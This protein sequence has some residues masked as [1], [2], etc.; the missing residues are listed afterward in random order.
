MTAVSIPINSTS[1]TQITS[2][3][4]SAICW[5]IKNP[6]YDRIL[7]DHSSTGI[8][9]LSA[10][11]AYS[12]SRNKEVIRALNVDGSSDIFYA[13]CNREGQ[14]AVVVID[15]NNVAVGNTIS[16]QNS[17]STP[18]SAAGY[19]VG[20]WVDITSYGIIYVNVYSDVSSAFDGLE[21]QQSSDGINADHSDEFTVPASKGKNYSINPHS[22]Y[23]RVIYYNGTSDQTEF[24]LQ[25]KL[26]CSGLDSSHR[27]KDDL[28]TDDDA[29][30][31]KS[32]LMTKANDQDEYKNIELNNPMPVN[33]GQLYPHDIN[34][35]HS[36]QYNFSGTA[37]DLL[38]DRWSPIVD[39]TSTNPKLL[40]MEFERPM[41]TSIIGMVTE[42]GDFS[43]VVVKF[44][45][46]GG[47]FYTLYDGSSDSTKRTILVTPS[48]PITLNKILLEFHTTD[49]VT[50]TG[51]NLAKSNQV[52]S[53]LQG[54]DPAGQLRTI[55]ATY[56]DNLNVSI[57]EYGDT[58]AI[59]P[60]AS[61]R[62]STPFTIFDSK[63]LYDNQPL[64][65]DESLGGSTT[66]SHSTT[67]ARTR[68]T[69]T[70]SASDF[71]IRQTK[72]RFNYQPGKGQKIL[73]TSLTTQQTGVL[74][75]FGLFD[76][77]STNYMTPNNGIFFSVSGTELRWNIAKNGSTTES[78]EQA[79]WNYDKLD[80]SG[81]SRITFNAAGTHIAII[82]FEWLG[83]GRVRVG[84]VID[85]IIRYVHYF[86]HSNT[87][88]F[89]SIY[90]S[91]PNL[92]IRYDIQSDGTGS[93][94]ID[95]ICST[96]ISE[97]GL[98]ETGISRSIDTAFTQLDANAANTTYI[99]LGLRLKSTHLD[100]TVLPE[101][102]SMISQTNDDFRWSL[103]LNPTYNG[104][105]TWSDI[106]NSGCQWARGD[107]T[108]VMTIPG[109]KF[110]SG[111]SKSASSIDRRIKTS[112]RIGSTINL[113]RDELILAAMPLA[114]NAD[115]QGSLTFRELL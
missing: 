64:F 79:D 14:T 24:R 66:S 65:Y 15:D 59:D 111:Y 73:L 87:S 107:T 82:D 115:L 99:M 71:G 13:R 42:T 12:L 22:K 105:L 60:F 5:V 30:L 10:S 70:A 83:V 27:V 61:L 89:T 4:Q 6:D 90:M 28:T 43:N 106:S 88:S 32:I 21:I 29:R 63:Q 48:I 109:T 33:G 110:D 68:L 25:T 45:I 44:A 85:G 114:S 113:T 1:W 51:F 91:T 36:D 9:T 75:R 18:L 58:P 96:V 94:F 67:E 38:D 78:V 74:K 2:A 112:L 76:G 54:I 53:Q 46:G 95:H 35:E 69:V 84:F 40:L 97:G 86:S 101:F 108:N 34:L 23:L 37:I 50:L 80:G 17:T 100:L 41:Q 72:Q 93:G 81:P 16:D 77:T 104:T 102:I 19:W 57:N 56:T 47:P 92:P 7:V 62:V 31:V 52:I 98:E 39:S 11:K 103:H 49:T 3:G 8:G 55:G 26:N 20:E